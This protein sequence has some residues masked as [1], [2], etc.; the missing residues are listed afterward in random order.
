MLGS[1][2]LPQ[3]LG[4]QGLFLNPATVVA[5]KYAPDHFFPTFVIKVHGFTF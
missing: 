4:K 1:P 2:T 3:G 5:K